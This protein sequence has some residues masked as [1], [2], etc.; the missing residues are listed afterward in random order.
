MLRA[1]AA[2]CRERGVTAYLSLETEMA[3]GLGICR[4]CSVPRPGGGYA[5][6]CVDGPVFASDEVLP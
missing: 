5:C 4:G 1:V 3:C 6:A 2:L